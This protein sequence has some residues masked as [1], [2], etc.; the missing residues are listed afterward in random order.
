MRPLRPDLRLS[1][2]NAASQVGKVKVRKHSES[3]KKVH[4]RKSESKE[5]LNSYKYSVGF[6][7]EG[8]FTQF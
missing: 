2:I 1:K 5:C 4:V 8:F 7:I 3:E 6:I